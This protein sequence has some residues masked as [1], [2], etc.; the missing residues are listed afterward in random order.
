MNRLAGLAVACAI[1]GIASGLML[2]NAQQSK[3]T[4]LIAGD[5]PVTEEQ[6]LAK[7]KLDGWSDVVMSRD[8]KYLQVTGV[9]NGQQGKIAVD[10]QTGRLRANDDDDDDDD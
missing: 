1:I 5:R 3:E 2:A 8:G 4:V 9:L 7:L 10:S 6:V